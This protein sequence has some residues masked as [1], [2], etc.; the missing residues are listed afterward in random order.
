MCVCVFT[1]CTLQVNGSSAV[2]GPDFSSTLPGLRSQ[3]TIPSLCTCARLRA[4]CNSTCACTV[5]GDT[6]QQ[7]RVSRVETSNDIAGKHVRDHGRRESDGGDNNSGSCTS[8]SSSSSRA[9]AAAEQ[10]QSSSRAAAAGAAAAAVAAAAEQ[11]QQSSSSSRA[12]AEQQQP[13]QSPEL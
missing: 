2:L 4:T 8:G 9:A 1:L 11:Q 12:A 10:Q 3:C 13:L 5:V 6:A 7:K